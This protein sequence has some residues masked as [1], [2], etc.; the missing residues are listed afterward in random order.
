MENAATLNERN[1]ISRGSNKLFPTLE[2]FSLEFSFSLPTQLKFVEKWICRAKSKVNIRELH[3][4]L[5]QL[6]RSFD[7]GMNPFIGSLMKFHG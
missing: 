3:Q 5:D 7:M 1:R 4:T 6:N 2:V